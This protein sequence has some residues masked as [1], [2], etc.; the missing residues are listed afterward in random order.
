[1]SK[2]SDGRYLSY[3][4]DDLN[5]ENEM[6]DTTL[7]PLVDALVG[8]RSLESPEPRHK[9]KEKESLQY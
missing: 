6:V 7:N 9:I 8:K 1:M 4:I 5:E 2:K 3:E